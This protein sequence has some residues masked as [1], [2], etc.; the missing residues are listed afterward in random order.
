MKDLAKNCF[1][2]SVRTDILTIKK[3]ELQAKKL[4]GII[5][6]KG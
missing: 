5:G 3:F 4:A 2:G 6:L 1:Q